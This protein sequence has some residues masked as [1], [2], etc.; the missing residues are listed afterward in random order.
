MNILTPQA[1][2]LRLVEE[3]YYLATKD[4]VHVFKA[5]DQINAPVLLKGPTGCGKSRFVS[6]MAHRLNRPLITVSCH[7]DLNANDLIG[8]F[9]LQGD[10]TVW[11]DGPLTAAVRMGAIVY[12]D[13]IVEAR[14]DTIVAIHSLTD[15]RRQLFIDK[16]SATLRATSDFMLVVSYNPGYQSALKELKPS[17]RQRFV[18]IAFDHPTP[19]I[20]SQIIE[21]ESQLESKTCLQLA[22]LGEQIRTLKNRG[23]EEGV[24][25][26]L[27]VH[28]AKLITAGIPSHRACHAALTQGLTDDLEMAQAISALIAD[29]IV[30]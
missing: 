26:R 30:K 20:E 29:H 21:K 15:H 5:A 9:L 8:R 23:L 28:A 4:E 16:L 22:R 24:S 25:T 7:E 6:H 27:L 19:D 17:T 14:K 11:S 1:D 3:P 2:D 12:L 18:S 13:E 10:E